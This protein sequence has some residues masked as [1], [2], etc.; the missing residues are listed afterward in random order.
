MLQI[1]SRF[2][3]DIAVIEEPLRYCHDHPVLVDPLRQAQSLGDWN[4]MHTPSHMVNTLHVKEYSN[5][6]VRAILGQRVGAV[7]RVV[8]E[9]SLRRCFML[10]RRC[11]R[12]DLRS[13]AVV[14]VTGGPSFRGPVTLSLTLPTTFPARVYD[15]VAYSLYTETQLGDAADGG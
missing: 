12:R 10:L 15:V 7:I 11:F 3:R 1:S 4:E 5:Y 6:T 14:E 8:L 13:V 2:E 9:E